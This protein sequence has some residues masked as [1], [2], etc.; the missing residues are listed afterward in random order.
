MC[1]KICLENLKYGR[2][3]GE[4]SFDGA[5][6]LTWILIKLSCGECTGCIWLRMNKADLLDTYGHVNDI[7]CSRKGV[8]C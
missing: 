7:S 4:H 2:H 6:I 1:R 8:S 3:V 5:R